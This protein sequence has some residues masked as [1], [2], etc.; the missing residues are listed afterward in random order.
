MRQHKS[1]INNIV[2]SAETKIDR[3]STVVANVLQIMGETKKPAKYASIG[4]FT[5]NI[6]LDDVYTRVIVATSAGDLGVNH[7]NTKLVVNYKWTEDCSTAVQ[8]RS[9]MS[10]VGKKAV[11]VIVT[12][13]GSYRCLMRRFFVDDSDNAP[14]TAARPLAGYNNSEVASP[15]RPA[16]QP[17]TYQRSA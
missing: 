13:I 11:L 1:K 15:S 6:V 14:S 10:R 7:P 16:K 5:S 9:Q 12:G 17:R 8:S 2:K 4:I 3:H